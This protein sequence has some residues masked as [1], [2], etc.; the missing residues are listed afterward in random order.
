V[1]IESGSLIGDYAVIADG[2]TITHDVTICPSKRVD[3]SI[4]E[5]HQVM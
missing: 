3:E 1:K 2:V 5:S 4:L